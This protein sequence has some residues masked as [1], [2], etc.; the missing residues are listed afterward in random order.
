MR[1]KR[2]VA[3]SAASLAFIQI[4]RYNYLTWTSIINFSFQLKQLSPNLIPVR[5]SYGNGFISIVQL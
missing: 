3:K 2:E 5:L 1:K 4:I